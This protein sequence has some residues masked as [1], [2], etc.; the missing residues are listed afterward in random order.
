MTLKPNII[1]LGFDVKIKDIRNY[2][3]NLRYFVLLSIF[4]FI[5]ATSVGYSFAKNYTK[6]VKEFLEQIQKVLEPIEKMEEAEQI[7]LI[8]L[9]N[10]L[11]G[12]LTILLGVLFG[13]FPLIV[14]FANGQLLGILIYLSRETLPVSKFLLSLLP[15]GIIEIP[16]LIICGAMGLKMGKIFA[17]KIFKREGKIKKEIGLALNFFSKILLP[18]L[19]LAA[20][21]ETLIT[22][23]LFGK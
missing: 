1:Y 23:K 20:V 19:F 12:F 17:D 11:T 14:L 5:F 7:L 9:N 13:L 2:L 16:V 22:P 8:F 6:E 21:V 3:F 18:L 15:H 4:L 10:S